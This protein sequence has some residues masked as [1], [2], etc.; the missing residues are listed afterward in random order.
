M[1][2]NTLTAPDLAPALHDVPVAAKF[3]GYEITMLELSAEEPL[4]LKD[5]EPTGDHPTESGRY[6]TGSSITNPGGA[7]DVQEDVP[8]DTD[9]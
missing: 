7:T 1:H 4:T 2:G 3:A 8:N 5:G 6:V 9:S